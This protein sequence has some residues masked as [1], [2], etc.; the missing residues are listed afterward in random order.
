MHVR[1]FLTRAALG[2]L[3]VAALAPA[4]LAEGGATGSP[5]PGARARSLCDPARQLRLAEVK[6]GMT[7]HGLSVFQG[8]KI[9]RFEVEVV[10][11]LKNLN[12]RYDVVLIR[13]KGANLEHTG[14]IA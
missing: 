5:A 9:E 2:G 7:G 11:I 13:C 1:Q 14:S 4:V 10:S 6:P 12:P 8:T 3:I